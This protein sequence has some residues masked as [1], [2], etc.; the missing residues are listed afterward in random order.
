MA[1]AERRR[2]DRLMLTM[3]LRVQGKTERGETFDDEGRTI[4][5]NRHGA[6]IHSKHTLRHGQIISLYSPGTMRRGSFRVAGPVE[7][8]SEAG[9]DWAIE[10]IDPDLNLWGIRF[11]PLADQE[12]EQQKALIECRECHETAFLRVTAAE[13]DVLE[14]AGII[15]REC[16][17]CGRET[18]WGYAP[19]DVA[20]Q[21]APGETEMFDEA[22]L[23]ATPGND[24]RRNRRVALQLPLLVR[25]YY[26]RREIT[27]TE[28]VSKTGLC[29]VSPANHLL[30]EG[31]VVVCPY[32]PSLASVEVRARV[33]HRE[34]IAA[35]SSNIYG[36][37]YE[38][39]KKA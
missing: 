1:E 12:N 32:D 23:A 4:V 25:D 30:G 39:Q 33:V 11:P 5:L 36:V 14:T 27:K 8:P 13:V 22:R 7:P 3:P 26:G 6:C 20:S 21:I 18:R 35:T 9:G 10:A 31:L 24:R 17:K 37:H 16:A 28:N 15:H 38:M 2:S 19:R 29:F 34:A